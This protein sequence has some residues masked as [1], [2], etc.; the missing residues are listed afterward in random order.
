MNRYFHIL[1]NFIKKQ[2][3]TN[4]RFPEIDL[5]DFGLVYVGPVF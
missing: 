1:S 5:K 3:Q 2:I 4:N